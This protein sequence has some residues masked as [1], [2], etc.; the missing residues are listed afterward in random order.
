MKTFLIILT[1][2]TIFQGC[3]EKNAFS[4]FKLSQKQELGVN[5]LQSS[6]L[7]NG[8]DV[9]GV[10]SV[11]YLNQTDP[12]SFKSGEV[13]YVFTY[14]KE[15]R[16]SLK[17]TLNGKNPSLYVRELTNKNDFT[18]LTS[19]DTKWNRYFVVTFAKQ[20]DVLNF[21]VKNGDFSSSILRFEKDE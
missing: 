19:I 2:L 5:S 16:S 14:T 17:F 8:E 1:F 13:F 7:K 4:R 12:D 10:V 6:K 20:G 21:Q 18:Y 3:G 15:K 9:N 11:I